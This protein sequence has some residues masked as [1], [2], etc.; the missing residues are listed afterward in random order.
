[1]IKRVLKLFIAVNSQGRRSAKTYLA[2]QEKAER[3]RKGKKGVLPDM[4]RVGTE[5]LK[6]QSASQECL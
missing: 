6:W 5:R 4:P 3:N 2:K 1:M